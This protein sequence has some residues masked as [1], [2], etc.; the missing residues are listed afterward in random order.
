MHVITYEFS[1]LI[2][3][4]L[5]LRKTRPTNHIDTLMS[6]LGNW[7]RM[8]NAHCSQT[9]KSRKNFNCMAMSGWSKRIIVNL[10]IG[11]FW[12]YP[13]TT[14]YKCQEMLKSE[15]CVAQTKLISRTAPE[16]NILRLMLWMWCNHRTYF[17]KISMTWQFKFLKWL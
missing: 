9:T 4:L 6:H 12:K 14:K 5:C 13:H 10:T 17:L 11:W 1:R 3:K 15:W 8:K 2:E 16:R 7:T